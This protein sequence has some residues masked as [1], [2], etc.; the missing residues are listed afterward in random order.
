MNLAL[1]VAELSRRTEIPTRQILH[2]IRTNY[3][4]IDQPMVADRFGEHAIVSV[5]SAV[6]LCIS[7]GLDPRR[8]MR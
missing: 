5:E 2:G 7:R 4:D 3:I 6:A 8:V 1:T